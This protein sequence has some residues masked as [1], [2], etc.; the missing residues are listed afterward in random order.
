MKK[1]FDN[2]SGTLFIPD[3]NTL[4][5]GI[6]ASRESERKRIIL[7]LHRRQ[8]AKVQ[9]MLNF[10]QPDTYIRPHMHPR[11][12]AVESIVVHKGAIRFF[13]FDDQGSIV[14][15]RKLDSENAFLADIE[16][17]TW[18]SFVVLEKDTILF[19]SKMGPYDA[20][21]DK[22]F[23]EWSPEEGTDEAHSWIKNLR[24]Q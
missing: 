16:P 22:I 11:N 19:E 15:D 3:E 18:H 14:E 6:K 17:L 12:Q 5:K 21:L 13:I 10:L 1:A 8:D 23:A 20:D 2:I 24:K 9:R 7:P 4:E